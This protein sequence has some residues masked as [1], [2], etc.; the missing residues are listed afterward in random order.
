MYIE[1]TNDKDKFVFSRGYE[2]ETYSK[3]HYDC[4]IKDGILVLTLKNSKEPIKRIT[5]RKC[6]RKN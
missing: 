2:R 4:S 1:C 6:Y 3:K 5:L